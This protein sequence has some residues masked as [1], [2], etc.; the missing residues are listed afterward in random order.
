MTGGTISAVDLMFVKKWAG[1]LGN[2]E[3]VAV[4]ANWSTGIGAIQMS[5]PL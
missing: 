5:M 1:Q 4:P 2:P 3:A